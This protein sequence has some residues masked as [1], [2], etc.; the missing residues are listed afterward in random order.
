MLTGHFCLISGIKSAEA[1]EEIIGVVAYL[2]SLFAENGVNVI[3]FS[4]CWHET[5]FIIDPK[6][7]SKALG[8]LKF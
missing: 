1:I 2:T 6:D 5:I 4:S 7:V 8:F 3:E